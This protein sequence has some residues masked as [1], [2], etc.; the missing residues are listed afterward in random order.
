MKR[1]VPRIAAVLPIGE[2]EAFLRWRVCNGILTRRLP[3]FCTR[4]CSVATGI[5]IALMLGLSAGPAFARFI[6]MPDT[7]RTWIDIRGN[8]GVEIDSNGFP[9]ADNGSLL[10]ENKSGRGDLADKLISP[11]PWSRPERPVCAPSTR[12]F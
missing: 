4:R 2:T 10:R 6:T 9:I 12:P 1:L 5:C 8:A 3:M 11:R 7:A